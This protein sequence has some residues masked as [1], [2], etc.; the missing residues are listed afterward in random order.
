MT[1]DTTA[2]A[3]FLLEIGSEEIPARFVPEAMA[4]LETRFLAALDESRL[5]AAGVR[6]VATPRRMALL[7]EAVAT[8]QPSREVVVKG[9]PVTVAFDAE[10]QPTKAGEGFARKAGVDLADCERASDDRGEYL[11]VRRLEEG[12]PASE[13]LAEIV[14]AVIRAL[15]FRK[16]MRWADHDLEYA[17]PLQWLVVLLGEDVVP[18]HLDHL[19]AGRVSRGHRTLAADRPLTIAAPGVYEETLREAGIIVDH[20]ERERLVVE[21]LKAV[22]AA[23]DPDAELRSDP[24]LVTEVVHLCEHP[25]PF[26]GAYDA[27]FAELP[28][29]VVATALKAHQRYFS[30][31]SPG[32]RLLPRFAAV[33]DGGTAHLDAVVRGNERV[34]RARLADALFYWEFDQQRRPD[35]RV[36]QLS[37]VTW[38]EGFGSVLDKTRRLERLVALLWERGLGDG[39]QAP[40]ALVRAATLSKSDLVSE[41]IR[42]GKEFTKLE[43]FMGARY[44]ERAGEPAEVCRAIEDHYAPRSATGALPNDPLSATL[45]V[46]DRL[47]NVAGCWLAGFAPTGAKDPYA[48]RRQVLAVARILLD[49]NLR[50]DLADALTAAL[51]PLAG[52]APDREL[53]KVLAELGAFVHRRLAGH[54]IE[55]LAVDADVVRA[56]LPARWA[57]P[58]DARAW[59][60]ALDGYRDRE[61]FLQLA[62]GFK[63]CRNILEGEVLSVAELE[64]CR[65]RWLAGGRGA[66][67]EDLAGLPEPAERDLFGQVA[68]LAVRLA[69]M[70]ARGDYQAV[71]DHLSSLGPA[72]DRFFD[73]V[74]V[75]VDDNDLKVRRRAFLR[76]IHGLFALFGDFTAV[77]PGED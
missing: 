27:A 61:D 22:V 62:T 74:R 28:D 2:Q 54:F 56:V 10:G 63:R 69:P 31:G 8:A 29:R 65:E 4:E 43:G 59:I 1:N 18:A 50:L 25:T 20:R 9:P 72:I 24:E 16:V 11:Q 42:D 41:M 47:D 36:A 73:E 21:G 51:E 23:W 60:E 75:N 3:P 30:V 14:P 70:E 52:C 53:A 77:A 48:L 37:S 33:R 34:L 5:A 13:V 38:F 32:G 26:L 19:A 35:E 17:R 64:A 7:A 12:R 57:D 15:P 71:F 49:R 40:A 66:G 68:D 58:V 76:E 45:A 44:A 55:T 67:G 39:G 6:V 46:A